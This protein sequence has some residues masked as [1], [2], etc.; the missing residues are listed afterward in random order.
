METLNKSFDRLRTNGKRLI[1]FVVRASI[2]SGQPFG[3][4]QEEPVNSFMVSLS[5]RSW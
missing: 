4:A 3:F 1:P 5:I 2:N